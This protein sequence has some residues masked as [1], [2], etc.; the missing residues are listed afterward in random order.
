MTS[1]IVKSLLIILT[2]ILFCRSMF[3]VFKTLKNTPHGKIKIAL[4]CILT[5]ALVAAMVICLTLFEVILCVVLL[6][7]AFLFRKRIFEYFKMILPQKHGR[8]KAAGSV[9]ASVFVLWLGLALFYRTDIGMPIGVQNY[10]YHKYWEEFDVNGFMG[11]TIAGHPTNQLTCC[12]KTGNPTTDAFNVVRKNTL[13]IGSRLFASDNYYGIIIRDDYEKYIA[14]YIDDYFDD[15]KVYVCFETSGLSNAK[16]M[17]DGFDKNTSLKDFL[18]FQKDENNIRTCNT[19]NIYIFIDKQPNINERDLVLNKI[20][21]FST[22]LLENFCCISVYLAVF[23][24]ESKYNYE[25]L[26]MENYYSWRNPNN[27]DYKPY[28]INFGIDFNSEIMYFNINENFFIVE[29]EN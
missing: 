26:T 18:D 6:L 14:T 1:Y 4:I 16:Y 12:P 19:A 11:A 28:Y 9:A 10:L 20:Q 5:I 29:G 23:G 15:Y 17:S 13:S 22:D 3:G 25:S 7:C 24:N 21:L 8:L 2:F 27:W